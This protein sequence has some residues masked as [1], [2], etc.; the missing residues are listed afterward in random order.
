VH[1]L[2]NDRVTPLCARTE[3]TYWLCITMKSQARPTGRGEN[4]V[5]TTEERF[6]DEVVGTVFVTQQGARI[7]A[8]ARDLERRA[9]ERPCSSEHLAP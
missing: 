7:A 5:E 6:L 3:L 8:E 2:D 4:F 9:A 1:L